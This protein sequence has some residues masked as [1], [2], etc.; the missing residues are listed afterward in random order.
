MKFSDVLESYR[1]EET[2]EL[3]EMANLSKRKYKMP[4]NL[5]ISARGNAKHGPR[6]KIQMNHS[7]RVD[8]KQFVTMT[9]PDK[10]LIGDPGDLSNE[11]I[12][13][14]E[15]FID[16]NKDVLLDY[17]FNGEERFIEDVIESLKFNV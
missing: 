7:D 8:S 3:N 6:I 2:N 12:E 1:L 14:F 15:R 5:Y 16:V 9:I 10:I 4:A 13:Y 17:W 11:D